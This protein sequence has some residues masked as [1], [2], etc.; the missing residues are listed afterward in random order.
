[1]N[2][3]SDLI[4]GADVDR[5]WDLTVDVERWP[6]LTPTMTSVERLDDGPIRV[7]SSARV[8]QP[9]QRPT[10]W[11]VTRLEPRSLFEWQTKVGTVTMTATHRLSPSGDSCRNSL[12]VVLSGFGSGILRRLVGSKIREAIQTENDGFKAAAERSVDAADEPAR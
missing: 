3:T 9:R 1:M 4:I 11:T 7:G 6:S 2:I 5:V 12:E 10:T 8:V